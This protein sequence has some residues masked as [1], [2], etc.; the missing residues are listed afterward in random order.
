MRD[1]LFEGIKHIVGRDAIQFM[2]KLFS[3]IPDRPYL[4]MLYRIRTGKRLNLENPTRFN[5]KLQWIKLYDRK[6]EYTIMV[7]KFAV[8]DYVSNK[9]GAKYVIPLLGCWKTT[10]EID[11]ASLPPRFVLKCTHDSY[12]LV[13][14]KD[15]SKLDIK[16]VKK[17]LDKSLKNN[18]YLSY[19]EWPYKNVQPRIIAEE[20]LEDYSSNNRDDLADYKVL[21]FN[22]EPRF[23][24]LHRGRFSGRH[25]QEFYDCD[26]NLLDISQPKLFINPQK[27]GKPECLEEMLRLSRILSEGIPH[28]RVD[29][30]IANGQLYFGELTFF[31][32]SGFFRFIPDEFDFTLGSLITLPNRSRS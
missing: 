22:G 3:F 1:N 16:E 14:C 10:D 4:K 18:F 23:I 15:K 24:E 28:I 2:Y 25:S 26:W 17:K 5:E 7:D 8:K 11:F 21:C 9:I 20:Y 31:D 27:V 6:E 32:G 12:G 13:I 19:R 29:W 30:Y